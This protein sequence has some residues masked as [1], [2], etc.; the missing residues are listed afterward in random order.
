[1][2][3][4]AIWATACEGAFW[5]AGTFARAYDRNRAEANESIIESDA[6]A[7]AVRSLMA[8][9]TIWEGFVAELLTVLAEAGEAQARGKVWPASPRALS[10]RLR[11]AAPNL[12]R[13]GINIIFGQHRA[14]GTP[15]RI[16]VNDRGAQPSSSSSPS[17]AAGTS[18]VRDD[19][20][21]TTE[22]VDAS[23]VIFDPWELAMNDA[24]D[25]R[26]GEIPTFTGGEASEWKF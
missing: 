9:T 12:R 16:E 23:T 3:D 13:V 22:G 2:A 14:K 7:L 8:T 25:F 15:I 19:D 1:M 10:G 26:D 20:R 17:S 5:P 21:M 4:F 18:D 6:V 24:D 11:R